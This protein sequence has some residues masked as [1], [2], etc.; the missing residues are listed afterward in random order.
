LATVGKVAWTLAKSVTSPSWH[1][2]NTGTPTLII[3]G[4]LSHS[5]EHFSTLGLAMIGRDQKD[6]VG[7][8]SFENEARFKAVFG[9][10]NFRMNT[11]YGR[12]GAAYSMVGLR[13]FN[14]EV[15]LLPKNPTEAKLQATST[16]GE[17]T[18]PT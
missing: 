15:S 13:C 10:N 5:E 7:P 3:M 1:P 6:V 16:R 18:E 2:H 12:Y 17:S 11:R 4:V 8:V 9:T 14:E